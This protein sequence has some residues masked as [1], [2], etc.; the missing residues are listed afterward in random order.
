MNSGNKVDLKINIIGPM[1]TG[2]TSL[3]NQYVHKWFL[4]DYQN[5]LGAHLLSKIIQLDNTNL[6]LQ[7]WD[8]GGQER[9]RTLVSTFYKGSDGCLLVFDVTDE[10]SFSCLEFWRK[11]FLD[12]IP[13]PAADFP[14]IV[15]GNKIDLDDRQVSKESAM[16]WCKGKNLSYLEVSAKNN[17]NVERAFEM[18]AKKALI[19]Y[20]ESKESCLGE[21]IKLYPTEDSNSNTCC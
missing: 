10:E 21:S 16:T 8:T 2:K 20:Q 14:M 7:I 1:G 18:L 4:N 13:P 6:N 15:L 5:T 17:V 19:H 12:K 11:D 3:L 9:F